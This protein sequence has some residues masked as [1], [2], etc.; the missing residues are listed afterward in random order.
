MIHIDKYK[1]PD[2]FQRYIEE[3]NTRID[4]FKKLLNGCGEDEKVKVAQF[5]SGRIKDLISAQFSRNESVNI[6]RSNVED[7]AEYLMICGFSSYSEYVDFLALQIIVGIQEEL[8]ISVPADYDDD[9]TKL[10]NS[11]LSKKDYS[12][13]GNLCFPEYYGVY[14]DYCLDI[15]SLDE[16]ISYVNE[17]WYNAS[18]DL[19][20]FNS[21]QRDDN[22]YT[23]YLN[24]VASAIIRMKN[25][26]VNVNNNQYY[27][28]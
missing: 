13:T 20:W 12:L 5:I 23:G 15:I 16:L 4:K 3:Q 22:T 18:R 1:N 8:C 14:R 6:I 10:L 17:K 28:V 7:Y 27:L 21:H 26:C 11:Y 2:Y 9:L 25:D 24:Y 19:Y